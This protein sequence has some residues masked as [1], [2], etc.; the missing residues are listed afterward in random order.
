MVLAADHTPDAGFCAV[1]SRV[2]GQPCCPDPCDSACDVPMAPEDV[3]AALG[4]SY[5]VPQPEQACL[6]A[7]SLRDQIVN[8][9]RPVQLFWEFTDGRS[10]AHVGL[11]TGYDPGSG[12]FCLCD[13]WLG[14][15]WVGYDYLVAYGGQGQWTKTYYA[16]APTA[17]SA[18]PAQPR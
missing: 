18:S 13:P 2:T 9:R 3:F 7:D 14:P 8:G 1:V 4:L 17:G 10:G 12:T 6:D 5:Q 11:V 16:I 15:S